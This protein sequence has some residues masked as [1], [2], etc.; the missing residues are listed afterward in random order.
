MHSATLVF[1]LVSAVL[2]TPT[3]DT[4][5]EL[6]DGNE[7]PN[8][9][10]Y[11]KCMKQH[12]RNYPD[13]DA[14]DP[15][16]V[17]LCSSE[18]GIPAQVHIEGGLSPTSK[19]QLG[20]DDAKY[21]TDWVDSPFMKCMKAKY[22]GFPGEKVTNP[23]AILECS[24]SRKRQVEDDHVLT[25]R[26]TGLDVLGK[27]LGLNPKCGS[28]EIPKNFKEAAQF[29]SEA[30]KWCDKMKDEV[31]EKGATTINSKLPDAV[32]KRASWLHRNQGVVLTL[33][34]A[35][36]PQGKKILALAEGANS[37]YD[38]WCKVAFEAFGTKDQGCTGELGFF[39]APPG[40]LFGHAT[41]TAVTDGYMDIVMDN[42]LLG[43]LAVD[44]SR[45][46]E[47]APF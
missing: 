39:K 40:L 18:A 32:T 6:R 27:F 38:K 14:L 35:L 7:I 24:S 12:Y 26:N 21:Q 45:P 31:L 8:E 28:K 47:Q 22:P 15:A 1:L 16:I 9:A 25:S 11:V 3:P 17:K 23:E 41:T 43:S 29:R 36:T 33:A 5:H 10:A 46:G 44:W 20:D 19:L 30:K 42:E 37:A 13:E 2:A 34:L 4:E